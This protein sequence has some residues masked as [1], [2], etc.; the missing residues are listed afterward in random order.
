MFSLY[1]YVTIFYDFVARVE[2]K[3]HAQMV[4]VGEAE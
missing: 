1:N 3:R 2:E 4:L